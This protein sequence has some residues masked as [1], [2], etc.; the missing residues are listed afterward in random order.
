MAEIIQVAEGDA[1]FQLLSQEVATE[2]AKAC[3]CGKLVHV[4]ECGK[5]WYSGVVNYS[6]VL[7]EDCRRGVKG[8]A[9]IVCLSCRTLQGFVPPQ[10]HPSGF[11][12]AADTHYHVDGCTRCKPGTFATPVLEVIAWCKDQR[13][14]IV[15]DE[16]IVKEA[17]RKTLTGRAESAKV[18]ESL[19]PLT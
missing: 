2:A 1:L 17:E 6:E 13:I 9:R 16:D 14:P 18:V 11:R 8:R 5:R 4:S 3:I 10:R 12:F 19:T 7:C 15:R